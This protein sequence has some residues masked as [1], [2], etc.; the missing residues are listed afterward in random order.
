MSSRGIRWECRSS[1]Q[2]LEPFSGDRDLDHSAVLL[3]SRA[4]DQTSGVQAVHEPRNIR[5]ARDRART[6]L[7][8][9]EGFRVTSAQDAE[10]VV[11]AAREVGLGLEETLPRGQDSRG[12]HADAEHRFLLRG[13]ERASLFDVLSDGG[14]HDSTIVVET[15]IVKT[16]T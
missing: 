8:R 6:D 4:V 14:R 1:P 12:D 9:G 13:A 16:D 7:A 15:D 3:A 2:Q 11:L 5:F 10:H